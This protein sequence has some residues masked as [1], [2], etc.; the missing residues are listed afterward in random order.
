MALL[1]IRHLPEEVL[2]QKAKKVPAIDKS[3]QMLIDD[4][5]ETMRENN[6]IGLAAPQ[7]GVSLRL[8]VLQMP[9]KEPMVL[10]N[11]EIVKRSGSRELVEGCLSVPGYNGEIVRSE[12]IT[13]K[14]MDRDGKKIRIKA[15]GLMAQALEHELDHLNGTLY[16]DYIEDESKLKKMEVHPEEGKEQA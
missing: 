6:G 3:T 2:R 14:A 4:M 12:T 7:V 10:I 11:P 8:A 5:L 9:E 1:R 16:L 15:E 13:V